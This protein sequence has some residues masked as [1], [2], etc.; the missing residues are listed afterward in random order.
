MSNTTTQSEQAVDTPAAREELTRRGIEV[1]EPFHDT[2]GVFPVHQPGFERNLWCAECLV[3][4]TA[5][6]AQAEPLSRGK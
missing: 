2:G 1:S 3:T 6:P 5:S 4:L